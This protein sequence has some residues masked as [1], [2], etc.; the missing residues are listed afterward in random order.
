[1]KCSKEIAFKSP[2]EMPAC[3]RCGDKSFI[4]R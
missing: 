1:E 2:S 4:R 3:P